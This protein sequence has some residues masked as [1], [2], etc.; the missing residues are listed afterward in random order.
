MSDRI[1]LGHG[2]G[3]GLTRNLIRIFKEIYNLKSLED[4]T[5]IEGR[6]AVT[7]DSFVV[8]PLVFPGGDIG[9]LS[10]TGTVNDLAM[11]GAVPEYILITYIIE[12]GFPIDDLVK[13]SRSAQAAA[14]EA[15]VRI[16]GG[17]TKVVEKGKGD[18]IY[19]TTF[20]IGTIPDGVDLTT[21][22]IKDGDQIMINGYIGDHGIAIINAR[23]QFGFSLNLKSDCAPLSG[24]VQTM[25]RSGDI[26]FLR[27]PTRG[28]VATVLNE[29]YEETRLGIVIDEEKLPIRD[30]V[31]GA[32]ELL[33]IDPLYVA[34]EGKLLAF[35]GGD[36][37]GKI[38]AMKQ[39]KYGRASCCIGLVDHNVDGVYLKTSIG[40]MRPLL[41]LSADP[42]PR[43]C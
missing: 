33:G 16:I 24:L 41:M 6:I 7:A 4:A 15:K 8:K 14:D 2:S 5:E 37:H 40:S 28:G 43:I 12:E 18:G 27:D 29:V 22:R 3:G 38:R 31:K 32:C 11:K 42:L 20:G 13:I 39:T 1:T 35:T 10:V 36:I 21:K 34:N 19:L 17:D 9:K 25:L 30:E 26:K 23:E